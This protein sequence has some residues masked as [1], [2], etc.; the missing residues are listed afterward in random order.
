[1][2]MGNWDYRDVGRAIGR[3][4][5]IAGSLETLT[6]TIRAVGR[7]TA[8]GSAIAIALDPVPDPRATTGDRL[9]AHLDAGPMSVRMV[10]WEALA[11]LVEAAQALVLDGGV[12]RA[13]A[14]SLRGDLRLLG[15]DL[16]TRAPAATEPIGGLVGYD[17]AV[18]EAGDVKPV[19]DE[20]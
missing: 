9:A 17:P 20:G 16:G 15:F 13:M 19:E 8:G 5:A 14:D 4:E 1:M 6:A 12:G 7:E 18:R 3:L 10:R 11:G 2:I